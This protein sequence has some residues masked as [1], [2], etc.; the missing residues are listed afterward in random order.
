MDNKTTSKVPCGKCIECLRS[1]QRS[2]SFRLLQEAKVSESVCFITLTYDETPYSPNGFP[3]LMKEDFQKFMKRLRKRI[4][5][6]Y[7]SYGY[8]TKLQSPTIKYYA[9]GEY[10]TQTYRPHYHAILFNLPLEHTRD[11]SLI[12]STWG[13]GIVHIGSGNELTF[14]YVAKYIMKS[15]WKIDTIIDTDTGEVFADDR[16]KEFSLMSKRLGANFLTPAMTEFL[17][18][19]LETYV[20]INGYAYPLPRYY[21][22][23][24]FTVRE[25][26]IMADAAA[27]AA[28]IT[29]EKFFNGDYRQEREWKNDQIRKHKKS[30]T[31]ERVKL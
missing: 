23:R 22:D 24:V 14:N 9:C 17:K 10:G 20:K 1:R 4:T 27:E 3:T 29:W 8:K 31:L 19:R 2:W 11:S 26:K 6:N 25:K 28:E 15:T 18:S 16:Q 30:L 12:E 21:K 7:L 13:K 5:D